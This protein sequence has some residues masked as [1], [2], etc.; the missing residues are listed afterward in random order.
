MELVLGIVSGM[1]FLLALS[2]IYLFMKTRELTRGLEEQYAFKTALKS[3]LDEIGEGIDACTKNMEAHIANIKSLLVSRNSPGPSSSP[4]SGLL[5]ALMG[6][7]MSG[8]RGHVNVEG[9]SLEDFLKFLKDN[10]AKVT[11]VRRVEMGDKKTPEAQ[12]EH[13]AGCLDELIAGI[14]RLEFGPVKKHLDGLIATVEDWMVIWQMNEPDSVLRDTDKNPGRH[15]DNLKHYVSELSR[16]ESHLEK[17][18]DEDN[19]EAFCI[20]GEVRKELTQ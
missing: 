5:G 15:V 18:S 3:Y 2:A 4:L 14:K 13:L 9:D 7:A 12:I 1:T 16:A 19:S 11:G 10:G 6:G 20:L 17:G 8:G